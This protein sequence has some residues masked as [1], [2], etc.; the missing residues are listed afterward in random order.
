MNRIIP[1][2][3]KQKT[4]RKKSEKEIEEILDE[5]DRKRE[6]RI[7]FHERFLPKKWRNP[8][9]DYHEEYN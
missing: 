3:E 4:P 6:A 2:W 7:K 8:N 1:Y 9:D 5:M